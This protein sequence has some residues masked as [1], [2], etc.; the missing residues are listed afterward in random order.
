MCEW[1]LRARG[2]RAQDALEALFEDTQ[3]EDSVHD[4]DDAH[5]DSDMDTSMD[6]RTK[7]AGHVEELFSEES[8]GERGNKGEEESEGEG[9]T[10]DAGEEHNGASMASLEA[11]ATVLPPTH[12]LDEAV[13]SSV[14]L[15]VLPPFIGIEHAAPYDEDQ[16]ALDNLCEFEAEDADTVEARIAGTVRYKMDSNVMQ[17]PYTRVWQA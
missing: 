10:G 12:R 15:V 5:G 7:G 2:S 8:E 1:S 3:D 13:T 9:E 11:S 17:A 6:V 14:K 4:G 16:L